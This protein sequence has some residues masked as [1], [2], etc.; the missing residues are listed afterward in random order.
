MAK[1]SY[2]PPPVYIAT[3]ADGTVCRMS[4]WSQEGKPL[5]F[6]RGRKVCC[7]VVADERAHRAVRDGPEIKG[8]D[9]AWLADRVKTRWHAS[10]VR[11]HPDNP[12]ALNP[13]PATDI[14][15]GAFEHDGVV[16]PDPYFTG[17]APAPKR[18]EPSLK[19]LIANIRKL[20]AE[21]LLV[22][23]DE[24]ERAFETAE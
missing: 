1:R 7:G 11:W 3:F 4:I 23:S 16:I 13:S 24:I 6:E 21:Q 2:W 18:R 9:A 12:A 10:D 5:D 22:L 15:A 20:S 8:S 19:T 14:V 17:E